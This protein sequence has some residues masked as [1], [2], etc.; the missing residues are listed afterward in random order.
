MEMTTDLIFDFFGTL[1]HYTP[2]PLNTNPYV[3]THDYLLRQ[4]FPISYENFAAVYRAVAQ[5]LEE[6]A[7]RTGQEYHM[8]DV[9]LRF[10]QSAFAV[11]VSE[12]V[13]TS[14][15][16]V[17]LEEWNRGVVYLDSIRP[18]LGRLAANYRLS[19]LSNTNYAPLIHSHLAAMGVV[20]CFSKVF[21]SVEIGVRKPYPAIFQQALKQLDIPPQNAIYIGDSYEADYQGATASE[22]RCI[23]IDPAGQY[24][25]LPHRVESLFVLE[26]LL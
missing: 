1:V 23:L 13:I 3:K 10:F 24:R 9:C 19:I 8:K 15:V 7:R 12:E 6:G 14:F 17:Y 4:G 2:G 16:S 25:N 26:Q 20:E 11:D 21:T 18:F 5:E 22:I